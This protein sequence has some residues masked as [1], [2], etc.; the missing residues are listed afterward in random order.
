MSGIRGRVG[1]FEL[2]EVRGAVREFIESGTKSAIVRAGHDLGMVTMTEQAVQFVLDG[3]LSV[4]EAFRSCY[5]GG[6]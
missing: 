4:T 5:F 6:D 3:K 2:L 1:L